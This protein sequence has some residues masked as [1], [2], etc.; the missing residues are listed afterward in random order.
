MRKWVYLSPHFDDVVLSAGGLV[1]EQTRWAV[2]NFPGC[3][4]SRK[5]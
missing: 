4:L 1:W 2:R 3:D 5:G